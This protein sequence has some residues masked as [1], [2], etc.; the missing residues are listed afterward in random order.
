MILTPDRMLNPSNRA[1]GAVLGVAAAVILALVNS[2]AG[3]AAAASEK[4]LSFTS[5][6]TVDPEI[7]RAH[8]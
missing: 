5:Q 1:R 8:V 2:G 7:G 3:I 4:I 6:I